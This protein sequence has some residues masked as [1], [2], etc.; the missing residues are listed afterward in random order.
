MSLF[1]QLLQHLPNLSFAALVRKHSA[2]SLHEICN[3]LACCVEKFV[4]LGIGV[5]PNKS[6]LSYANQH[7]PAKLYE[8][9]FCKALG[10]FRDEK[11]LGRRKRKFRS[12]TT[13]T[14]PATS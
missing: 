8:D 7:R 1:S 11:G 6:T 13:I 10:R 4:H 3:G 2:D 5:A 14:C 9:L 12:I